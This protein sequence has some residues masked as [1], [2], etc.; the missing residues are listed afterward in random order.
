MALANWDCV[1]FLDTRALAS[2]SPN[3]SIDLP[4][5]SLSPRNSSVCSNE[6]RLTISQYVFSIRSMDQKQAIRKA[7]DLVGGPTSMA[8]A[9]GVKQATVSNWLLSYRGQV[10]SRYAIA[11][12]IA[13]GGEVTRHQL[14]PDLYPEEVV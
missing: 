14:R 13:T 2:L 11:V 1:S 7:I 10:S 5:E 4:I 6:S 3:D 9:L 8:R 12:E